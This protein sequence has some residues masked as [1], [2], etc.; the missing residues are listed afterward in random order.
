M[1]ALGTRY[2]RACSTCAAHILTTDPTSSHV[3][4]PA[5]AAKRPTWEQWSAN[6]RPGGRCYV[7][8][9][10]AWRGMSRSEHVVT[11][12][13]GDTVTVQIVGLPESRRPVT[14][15]SLC[16]HDV[17]PRRGVWAW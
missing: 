9:A 3:Y 10:A 11:A 16:P 5:C 12:R 17:T 13:D 14:I 6:L 7:Q 15:T 2:L 4:C 8:P 1:T